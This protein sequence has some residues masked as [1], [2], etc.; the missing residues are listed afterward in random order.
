[1]QTI[2]EKDNAF[3]VFPII[4]TL[5]K[6]AAAVSS[7][8]GNKL[9][10]QFE[11]KIDSFQNSFQSLPIGS[12]TPIVHAVFFHVKDFVRQKKMP[13]GIYSEQTKVAMHHCFDSHWERYKRPISHPEYGKRLVMWIVDFNSKNF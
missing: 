5:R 1:M 6:F 4:E 9:H 7:C 13:L 12:V 10:F 8:F 3:Q 11:E 2:A